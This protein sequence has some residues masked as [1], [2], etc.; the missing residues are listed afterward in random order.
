MAL[1]QQQKVNLLLLWW[2]LSSLYPLIKKW[3][4]RSGGVI[5]IFLDIFQLF[6]PQGKYLLLRFKRYVRL[7]FHNYRPLEIFLLDLQ[8]LFSINIQA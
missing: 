4:L 6:S 3:V 8:S 2:Q 7:Q 1:L 5:H